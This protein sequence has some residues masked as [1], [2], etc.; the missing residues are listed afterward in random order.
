MSNISHQIMWKK[1]ILFRMFLSS[2]SSAEGR[3]DSLLMSL[4]PIAVR[5]IRLFLSSS[6]ACPW[7]IFR[8]INSCLGG[9]CE[10]F[11]ARESLRANFSAKRSGKKI[12]YNHEDV[13]FVKMPENAWVKLLV[14]V[15]SLLFFLSNFYFER[16]IVSTCRRRKYLGWSIFGSIN[17]CVGGQ[18]KSFKANESLWPNF[19]AIR[20][21]KKIK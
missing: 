16:N 6:S 9:R 21:G 15:I 20:S 4:A 17:S 5:S 19:L 12:K 13:K 8:S 10:S 3:S 18:C 14:F 1:I 2:S 11:K 7:S